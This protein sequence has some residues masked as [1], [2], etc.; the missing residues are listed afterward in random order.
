MSMLPDNNLHYFPKERIE[1]FR[2]A[3]KRD[4]G[5]RVVKKLFVYIMIVTSVR[6]VN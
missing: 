2:L 5:L 3:N 4:T 1:R 6:A